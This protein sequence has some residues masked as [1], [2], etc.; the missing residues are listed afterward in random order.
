MATLYIAEFAGLAASQ[1]PLPAPLVQL[2]PVAEQT[3][4]IGT[5]QDSAAFS[6]NTRIIRVHADA[7]CS[8]K[9]GSG[10]PAA[11]TTNMRLNAGQTEYFAVN[12]GDKLSVIS[13]T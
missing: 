7:V 1:G 6:A 11:A 9:A 2:P 8:I 4:T 10:N 12:P 13:N 3:V 5:E